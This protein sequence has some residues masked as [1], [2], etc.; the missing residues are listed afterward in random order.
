MSEPKKTIAFLAANAALSAI[1]SQTLESEPAL[2][3]YRFESLDALTIFMRICPLDLIIL[4]ADSIADGVTESLRGLRKVP[5]LP[6]PD[7]EMMVLTRAGEAFHRPFHDSGANE[8]LTKPVMPQRLLR[9]AF[10]RLA[11]RQ[12]ELGADGVYRG[13]ERRQRPRYQ[14]QAGATAE[15]Q[16]N[17]IP[18]F[19]E[20]Q[21]R[22]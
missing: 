21:R 20:R 8:V 17:V 7:F 19:G 18:L 13:P 6:N 3:V 9:R 12:P 16:N 1:L 10:G 11:I 22:L 5:G 2:R 15:G 14:P 4:D